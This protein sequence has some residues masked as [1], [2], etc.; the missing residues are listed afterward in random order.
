M[1]VEFSNLSK[2]FLKNCQGD[3]SG[4]I[5]EKIERLSV[6]PFL[7]ESIKIGGGK[8][9]FRV[10]VGKYRIIYKVYSSEKY[11]LVTEI[12]KRGNIYK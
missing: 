7:S 11:I 4:R 3:D 10:R 8:D 12:G 9:L 1:K 6:N 2:K 5:I